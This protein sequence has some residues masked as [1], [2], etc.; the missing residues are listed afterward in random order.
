[1]RIVIFCSAL[2]MAFTTPVLVTGNGTLSDEDKQRNREHVSTTEKLLS[3]FAGKLSLIASSDAS[4]ETRRHAV[5]AIKQVCI[6]VIC[7][8]IFSLVLVGFI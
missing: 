3:E 2:E 5:S 8:L 7:M 4:S 6:Y 1:M